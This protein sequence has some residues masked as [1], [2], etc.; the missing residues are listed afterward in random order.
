MANIIYNQFLVKASGEG[1]DLSNNNEYKICLL[2]EDVL[3]SVLDP[4][5]NGNYTLIAQAGW[6]CSDATV[7]ED[8]LTGYHTGGKY[9]NLVRRENG[10]CTE[11]Y[12][13]NVIFRGVTLIGEDAARYALLYR[14][15]DGL[16]IS[17]FDLGESIEVDDDS[18]IL[19]WKD[20]AILRIGPSSM[21][22]DENLS[23]ESKNAVQNKVVTEALKRYGISLDDDPIPDPE[24]PQDPFGPLY[25]MDSGRRLTDEDIEEIFS[26]NESDTE[27]E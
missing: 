7:P 26:S 10:S 2:R 9:I 22:I 17:L 14:V 27:G 4:A 5:F 13:S 3:S 18:F 21:K 15:F 19:D 12:S 25:G 8:D 11:Y 6:E 1:V 23:A 20:A 24:D 16:M